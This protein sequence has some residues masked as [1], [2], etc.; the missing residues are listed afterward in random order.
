MESVNTAGLLGGLTGKGQLSERFV[1]SEGDEVW[2]EDDSTLHGLIIIDLNGAIEGGSETYNL[3]LDPDVVRMEVR[4]LE[5]RF[6]SIGQFHFPEL[7]M[8]LKHIG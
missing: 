1:G 5:Q 2:A 3:M 4:W 8:G 6:D 7:L